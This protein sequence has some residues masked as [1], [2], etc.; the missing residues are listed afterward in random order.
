M[1]GIDTCRTGD[2]TKIFKDLTHFPDIL[3]CNQVSKDYF[4]VIVIYK[5]CRGMNKLVLVTLI[6]F[7]FMCYE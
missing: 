5:N 1:F 6:V 4:I 2:K 3:K 7:K